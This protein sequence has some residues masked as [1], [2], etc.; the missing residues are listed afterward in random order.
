MTHTIH[1]NN[2]LIHQHSICVLLFLFVFTI[3]CP[4]PCLGNLPK[5]FDD[6]NDLVISHVQTWEPMNFSTLKSV[7]LMAV[8]S[9]PSNVHWGKLN[10]K[11]NDKTTI[12]EFDPG[13]MKADSLF[14]LDN[15]NLASPWSEEAGNK[16]R[17]IIF[18]LKNETVVVLLDIESLGLTQ[19]YVYP[20]SGKI[21]VDKS[22]D[23]Q[24]FE[25]RIINPMCKWVPTKDGNQE[26]LTPV[27][28]DVYQWNNLEQKYEK[29]HRSSWIKRFEKL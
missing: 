24:I 8:I 22:N 21:L 11:A 20:H 6:D 23:N 19:E 27:F 7:K 9:S 14:V 17:L 15:G 25:H 1:C 2:K 12:Y 18:G 16:H 28:A 4:L 3:Y 26:E 29:T 13:T 10:I 5:S